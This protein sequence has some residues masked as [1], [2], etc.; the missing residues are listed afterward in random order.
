MIEVYALSKMKQYYH[1]ITTA[2]HHHI[3]ILPNH[4]ILFDILE[5]IAL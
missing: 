4:V 2:V 1:R 5:Q 3:Y